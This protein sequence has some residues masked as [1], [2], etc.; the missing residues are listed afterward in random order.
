LLYLVFCHYR[1]GHWDMY[2][3]SSAAG[4]Q[5]RFDILGWFS[6]HLFNLRRPE[7]LAVIFDQRYFH[8]APLI[9]EPNVLSRV[10]IFVMLFVFAA[11]AVLEGRL[12]RVHADSGWRQRAVFYLCGW[13]MFFVPLCSH[14]GIGWSSMIRFSL[15]VQVVLVLA[16]VH[17]LARVWPLGGWRDRVVTALVTAWS[18]LGFVLQAALTYRFAHREWVA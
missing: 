4:W 6:P 5:V 8:R 3:R 17:L 18:L 9:V 2:V 12:A 1:Y 16:V 7:W 11:L 13:G 14:A 10:S 15:C